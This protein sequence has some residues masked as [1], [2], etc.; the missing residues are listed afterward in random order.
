MA[1]GRGCGPGPG[2]LV[3]VAIYMHMSMAKYIDNA[4]RTLG[5]TCESW[6]PINQPIDTDSP[7]LSAKGKAEFLT[8]VGMLQWMARSDRE[9]WR[10]L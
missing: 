6:V 2:D 8:A 3:M 4:C 1:M 5:I 7:E 9:V 10:E